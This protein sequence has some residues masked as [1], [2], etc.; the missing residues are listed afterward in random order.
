MQVGEID[1]CSVDTDYILNST[2]NLFELPAVVLEVIYDLVIQSEEKIRNASFFLPL[3]SLLP[4]FATLKTRAVEDERITLKS[5]VS[6]WLVRNS[7][8]GSS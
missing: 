3:F 6:Y 1:D 5:G 7:E 4:I 8:K 2:R